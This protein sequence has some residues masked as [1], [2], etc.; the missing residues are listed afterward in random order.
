MPTVQDRGQPIGGSLHLPDDG[1]GLTYQVRQQ[2]RVQ[3]LE[4]GT[5][6]AAGS[7]MAH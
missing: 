5:E 1:G 2:E 6:L 7:L 3:C 4:C